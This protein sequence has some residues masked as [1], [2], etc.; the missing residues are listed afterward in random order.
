[1]KARCAEVQANPG[2]LLRPQLCLLACHAAGGN[3]EQALPAAAER[4]IPFASAQAHVLIGQPGYKRKDP[5]FFALMVGNYILGGGGFVS[6]LSN[7]VRQK[8]GLSYSV[9]SYFSPGLHAGAFMVGL[10]TRPDQAEQ[11]LQV[12]RVGSFSKIVD[13]VRGIGDY[14][15]A[16]PAATT[17]A[18][19]VAIPPPLPGGRALMSSCCSLVQLY[20]A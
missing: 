7:E 15:R 14:L 5:D 10:Q 1:M 13:A 17:T 9:Y 11:A 8:R 4:N 16:E 6:R 19:G 20:C 12:S 18:A 2:K 3:V